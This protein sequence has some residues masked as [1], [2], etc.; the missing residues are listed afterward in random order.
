[1]DEAPWAFVLLLDAFVFGWVVDATDGVG[2]AEFE[3]TQSLSSA[4]G[5]FPEELDVADEGFVFAKETRVAFDDG[6]D[7]GLF[8]ALPGDVIA[9]HVGVAQGVVVCRGLAWDTEGT[10][11]YERFFVFGVL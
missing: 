3:A 5:A 4:K 1:M 8:I 2:C 11:K 6:A 10:G 7:E 9:S